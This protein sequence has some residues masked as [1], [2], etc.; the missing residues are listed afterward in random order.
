MDSIAHEI[1]KLVDGLAELHQSRIDQASPADFIKTAAT[2]PADDELPH[3]VEHPH[4][5]PIQHEVDGAP[6]STAR[7]FV[8]SGEM[9]SL[10][11]PYRFK[12]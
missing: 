7:R 11:R 2:Q 5:V 6:S 8:G 4:L 9:R 3:F 1:R 10:I 12:W